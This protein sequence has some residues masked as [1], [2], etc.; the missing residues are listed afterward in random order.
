M[1]AAVLGILYIKGTIL[2]ED[3]LSMLKSTIQTRGDSLKFFD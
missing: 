1:T 2:A 3:I